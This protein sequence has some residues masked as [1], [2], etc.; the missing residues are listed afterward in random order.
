MSRRARSGAAALAIVL[1]LGGAVAG[2]VGW[3]VLRGKDAPYRVSLR[4]VSPVATNWWVPGQETCPS[5]GRGE[6]PPRSE[7]IGQAPGSSRVQPVGPGQ[8]LVY[9]L[10]VEAGTRAPG[11]GDLTAA[12]AFPQP[13][14]GRAFDPAGIVCTFVDE[15]DPLT[16]SLQAR[17][18]SAATPA[19]SPDAGI[20][21]D[22]RL[23]GLEAE[24][25]AVVELWVRAAEELDRSTTVL[26]S[27]IV[28]VTAPA[29]SRS[30]I[31]EGAARMLR[32]GSAARA[33]IALDL[34]VD[35]A[36]PDPGGP[37]R[38]VM[39]V[40]NTSDD[41]LANHLSVRFEPDATVSV[42]DISVKDTAG[43]PTTC[44]RSGGE[45]L[46]STAYLVPGEVVTV[47]V[48]G[49]IA[50]DTPTLFQTSGAKCSRQGQ[51]LCARAEVASQSGVPGSTNRVELATD[52]PAKETL[53][54]SKLTAEADAVLYVGEYADFTYA[55]VPGKTAASDVVVSDPSCGPTV[56]VSG[57]D[58][59]D[60]VLSPGER[61]IYRCS[62]VV[63]RSQAADVTVTA[64]SAAG[65]AIGTTGRLAT[66]IL[67]PAL[68]LR[69]VETADDRPGIEVVNS[70]DAELSDVLVQGRACTRV[71][72]AGDVD[73]D[74]VLDPAERWILPC[75]N[76]TGPVRAY[77]TDQ[78]GGAVTAA[79][80][81]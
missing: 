45:I 20:R 1:V 22:V 67:D 12:M 18:T 40:R 74:G 32:S 35:S 5:G 58:G 72:V 76:R 10:L 24:S 75:E 47:Q 62:A 41:Q 51:D 69:T 17:A 9:E 60:R 38:Y 71:D 28:S 15:G 56:L 27:E 16:T 52:L 8:I 3:R 64:V 2:I 39:Q 29:G 68:T 44:T 57:D 49:L 54:L 81:P 77:A 43:L 61:W 66:P 23:T 70:G 30:T 31:V 13:A 46:C 4:P 37:I 21:A 50:A 48:S 14:K 25:S 19:A 80:G 11:I 6:G 78:A 34:G 73:R 7:F 79:I 59:A 53:G 55:V 63:D 65:E 26:G 36:A 33:P 42:S